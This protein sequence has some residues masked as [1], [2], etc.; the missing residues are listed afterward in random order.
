MLEHVAIELFVDTLTLSRV[1]EA[2]VCPR[3]DAAHRSRLRIAAVVALVEK[4]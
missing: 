3:R 4:F 1:P 2:S